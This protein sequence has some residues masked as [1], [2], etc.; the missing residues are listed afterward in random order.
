MFTRLAKVL[1]Q[2]VTVFLKEKM[3]VCRN[4]NEDKLKFLEMVRPELSSV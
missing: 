2:L 1:M 3:S 4:G